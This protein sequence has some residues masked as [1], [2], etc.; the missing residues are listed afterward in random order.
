LTGIHLLRSSD[1]RRRENRKILNFLRDWSDK[2]DSRYVYEFTHGANCNLDLAG[3]NGGHSPAFDLAG[4]LS[5]DTELRKQF[6][7]EIEA[8]GAQGIDRF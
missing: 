5:G 3:G 4:H 1:D 7:G 8:G 6:F 2:I